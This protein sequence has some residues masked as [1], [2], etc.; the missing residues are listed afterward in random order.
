MGALVFLSGPAAGLRYEITGQLTIGRSRA[1]EIAL[2]DDKV[3]RQHAR[4][5]LEHGEPTIRDL[6]SRNGT[7]V[8]GQRISSEVALLDGDRIQ[9]GDSTAKLELEPNVSA[10]PQRHELHRRA[11]A[12][13]LA[14]P[15]TDGDVHL[16]YL[17]L[18]EASSEAVILRRA[19]A[20]LAKKL[21]APRASAVLVHSGLSLTKVVPGPIDA[22]RTLIRE[23]LARDEVV[24]T[25]RLLCVPVTSHRGERFGAICTERDAAPSMPELKAAALLGRLTGEALAAARGRALRDPP[26]LIGASPA[27]RRLVEKA[28]R[29]AGGDQSL[30]LFGEAGSG[31]SLIA[32]YIHSQSARSC[33]ALV[34]VNCAEER[35]GE[36]LF[37]ATNPDAES[38]L[39]RAEGGTLVLRN[40]ELLS[41]PLAQRLARS[42]L[43]RPSA[44][45]GEGRFDVRT[46]AIGRDSLEVL[47]A[48]RRIPREL[49][50]AL[51]GANLQVPPLRERNADVPALFRFFAQERCRV[52]G[53]E[54][55]RP[56]PEA[57]RALLAYT[58]PG[59]VS[60]VRLVAERL[61]LLYSGLEVPAIRLPAEML[62]PSLGERP[63]S[64]HHRVRATERAA[65]AEALSAAGGKKI[66][67]AEILG[68]S[69][70]TLDKKLRELDLLSVA[71]M[72]RQ[73]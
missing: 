53:R 63:S 6:G 68:I 54:P 3:S 59:N 61:A 39:A 23:A 15:G 50:S 16:A 72:E 48:Q 64:L 73:R 62:A 36:E 44:A 71:A 33:G 17:D 42:L 66:R 21:A 25:G 8:N 45:R 29:V 13:L 43:T 41:R 67:A 9:L 1:C 10:D 26:V 30:S 60:E 7:R 20:R 46:I 32:Q 22:P 12:S 35:L 57:R 27:F 56:S 5:E 52:T 37:G 70:P 69:R 55:P 11:V 58:W 31:R 24:S 19:T 40:V 47:G 18:L 2:E 38:A 14:E 51:S 34:V 65:I 28:E 49:A 4:I